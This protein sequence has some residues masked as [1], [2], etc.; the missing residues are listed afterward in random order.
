MSQGGTSTVCLALMQQPRKQTSG[1]LTAQLSRVA[2]LMLT[3]ALMLV[4]DLR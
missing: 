3:A 4:S 1:R 2:T